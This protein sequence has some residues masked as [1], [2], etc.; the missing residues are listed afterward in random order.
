M[1]PMDSS[2]TGVFVSGTVG[3]GVMHKEGGFSFDRSYYFDPDHRWEQDLAIAR[4]CE[5]IYAPYPIHNA[6]AHLIQ[7]FQRRVRLPDALRRQIENQ[8]EQV[9]RETIMER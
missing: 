9:D 2:T 8:R 6:E 7:Y 3:I 4:W 5:R 1:A